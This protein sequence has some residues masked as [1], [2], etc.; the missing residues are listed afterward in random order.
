MPITTRS[1]A[2]D[3]ALYRRLALVEL[4]RRMAW[5]NALMLAVLGYA[6]FTQRWMLLAL[7]ALWFGGTY[8]YAYWRL[9]KTLT[10][11]QNAVMFAPRTY[12]FTLTGFTTEMADGGSR[13]HPYT[14]LVRIVREADHTRIYVSRDGFL[15]VPHDAFA[16]DADRQQVEAW[17]DA[18]A[19]ELKKPRPEPSSGRG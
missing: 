4:F 13:T 7:L 15:L 14:S 16:S 9:Q 2:P 11:P 5:V 19:D 18:V 8:G 10:D 12:T 3:P 6:V 17:L 1:F